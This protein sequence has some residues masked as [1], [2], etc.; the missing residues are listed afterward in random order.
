LSILDKLLGSKTATI[1]SASIRAEIDRCESEITEI[2]AKVSQ[3]RS[4]IALLT[5]AEHQ[6]VEQNIATMDRAIKRLDARVAH[7]T[8]ELPAI[9][10]AE[11]AQAVAERDAALIKRA[12]A[13][14]KANEREAAK[15][16]AEYADH[17]AVIADV[18]AKLGDITAETTAVN[19]ALRAHPIAETVTGWNDLHRSTPGTDATEQKAVRKCWVYKFP[20]SPRDTE[21]TSYQY[22][23]PHEEVR[24]ATIGDDGKPIPVGSV[25]HNYYGRELVIAPTLEER[26]VVIG[27]TYARP[28]RYAA[29]LNDVRLPP[30]LTAPYIWPRQ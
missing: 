15:L 17:A 24:E 29:T 25:I 1:T 3:A 10:A 30:A 26:E 23:A 21:S 28:T 12:S 5:D 13:A 9:L 6:A 16:L 14:R 7:L 22:E 8:D 18:L 4:G 20:G 11:E 2:H 27:R 19:E